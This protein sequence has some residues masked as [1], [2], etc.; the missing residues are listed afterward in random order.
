[1][2]HTRTSSTFYYESE[3]LLA[4]EKV[5]KDRLDYILEQLE[6]GEGATLGHQ[7]VQYRPDDKCVIEY[8]VD[9]GVLEQIVRVNIRYAEQK[10]K[11]ASTTEEEKRT[12]EEQ[13]LEYYPYL[14]VGVTAINHTKIDIDGNSSCEGVG[15][16]VMPSINGFEP[17]PTELLDCVE[18][19]PCEAWQGC[20]DVGRYFRVGGFGDNGFIPWTMDPELEDD[21]NFNWQSIVLEIRN[22]VMIARN[23]LLLVHSGLIPG[24]APEEA[25]ATAGD[26]DNHASNYW[27]Y[28]CILDPPHVIIPQQDMVWKKNIFNNLGYSY[29][30]GNSGGDGIVEQNL[31]NGIYTFHFWAENFACECTEADLHIRMVLGRRTRRTTTTTDEY[32]RENTQVDRAGRV[33]VVDFFPANVGRPFSNTTGTLFRSIMLGGNQSCAGDYNQFGPL[34]NSQG[35]W[36]QELRV[37]VVAGKWELGPRTNFSAAYDNSC[38]YPLDHVGPAD[39]GC[40][41]GCEGQDPLSASY[42]PNKGWGN[43]GYPTCWLVNGQNGPVATSTLGLVFLHLAR[44]VQVN[45]EFNPISET[46][47]NVCIVQLIGHDGGGGGSCSPCQSYG[48]GS[49]FRAVGGTYDGS[50]FRTTGGWHAGELCIVIGRQGPICSPDSTTQTELYLLVARL[51]DGAVKNALG[52]PGTDW[53]GLFYKQLRCPEAPPVEQYLERLENDARIRSDG[54]PFELKFD[55]VG[56]RIEIVQSGPL[57]GGGSEAAG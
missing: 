50:T 22:G 18:T 28:A 23:G 44:V 13:E 37:D 5:A 55:C 24:C 46:S 6:L 51:D 15:F 11:S 14:W 2:K 34:N 30:G 42:A 56:G 48:Y 4:Y 1:M 8:Y 21:G 31:Q 53:L 47:N 49:V 52:A 27:Q 54:L 20:E 35:Y 10:K 12:E 39:G 19:K 25:F 9:E 33:E 36:D 32:G 41:A 3:A 7:Q 45:P 16:A 43:L 40:A 26:G 38:P 57:G 29:S 17:E